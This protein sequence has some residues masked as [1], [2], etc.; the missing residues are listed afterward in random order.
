MNR[1]AL[2]ITGALSAVAITLAELAGVGQL[3]EPGSSVRPPV[4]LPPVVISATIAEEAAPTQGED[5]A[6]LA[7][8]GGL[9]PAASAVRR[10]RRRALPAIA[11]PREP[12]PPAA[13]D[14]H[15]E[16]AHR[17]TSLCALL[18]TLRTWRRRAHSRAELAAMDDRM[19]KDLGLSRAAALYEASKPFW[20]A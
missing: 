16:P 17:A 18:A 10:G 8:A 9:R 19:L 3:A 1:I 4:V 13:N 20:Q 11:R 2:R 7:A 5:P 15:T 6:T 12:S 14:C